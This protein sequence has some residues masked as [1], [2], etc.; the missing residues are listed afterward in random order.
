MML[1]LMLKRR[2]FQDIQNDGDG[3]NCDNNDK[4]NQALHF[5][6]WMKQEP[7]SMVWLP[8]LHRYFQCHC[9]YININIAIGTLAKELCGKLFT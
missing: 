6:N 5:L 9:Q 2:R 8:V 4:K 7:Q 1:M 3:N